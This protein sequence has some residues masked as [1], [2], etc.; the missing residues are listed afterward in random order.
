MLYHFGAGHRAPQG[1]SVKVFAVSEI[2]YNPYTTVLAVSEESLRKKPYSE[3]HGRRGAGRVAL[4]PGRSQG[5]Q[6]QMN[7]LNPAMDL[8]TFA[9]VAEVRT[10]Y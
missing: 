2:G 3:G 7:K 4:V 1:V 5:S 8:E 10:V 6:Q 9:E